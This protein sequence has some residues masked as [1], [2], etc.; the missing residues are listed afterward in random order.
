MTNLELFVASL[1]A[2][3]LAAALGWVVDSAFRRHKGKTTP[4]RRSSDSPS[5]E[6]RAIT[7]ASV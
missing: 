6:H 3:V 4:R 1:L 2:G 5:G 7:N